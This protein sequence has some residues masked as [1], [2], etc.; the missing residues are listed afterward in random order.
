MIRIAVFGDIC[1]TENK[2]PLNV[3]LSDDLAIGNLEC[4]MTDQ[5]KPKQKARL[6]IE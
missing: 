6:A 5:A 2:E 1:P 3:V 4:A